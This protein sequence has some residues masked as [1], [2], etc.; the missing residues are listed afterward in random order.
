MANVDKDHDGQ[1]SPNEFYKLLSQKFEA[2]DPRSDIENVY[3]RF[4]KRHSKLD[5]DEL[6]E[7]AMMLGETMS[8][9]DIRDMIANIKIL[10]E[11]RSK[12]NEQ[13]ASPQ[14]QIPKGVVRSPSKLPDEQCF[15]TMD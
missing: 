9:K 11:Q 2:G 7:V 15:L 13:Q 10:Y 3:R 14:G 5:A 12:E 6:Y 1:I 8:K 4:D